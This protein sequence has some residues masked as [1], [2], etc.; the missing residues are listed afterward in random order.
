MER[1]IRQL[2]NDIAEEED[3]K[4]T[5]KTPEPTE[6]NAPRGPVKLAYLQVG[7]AMTGDPGAGDRISGSHVA[8]VSVDPDATVSAAVRGV[9]QAAVDPARSA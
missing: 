7:S 6:P 1:A 2:S 4:K 8:Q 5:N 9:R 3:T